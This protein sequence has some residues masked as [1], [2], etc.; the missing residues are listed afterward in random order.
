M[1]TVESPI[2]G[3]S[4][5]V[6]TSIKDSQRLKALR[7]Y[8]ILDTE[9]EPA[10][11]RVTTMAAHLFDA[12]VSI[13]N[14]VEEDRQW[15]KSTV[16]MDEQETGLDVSF[17]IYTVANEAPFV[18]EDLAADDRFA[19]NPYVVEDGIRFYAGAPLTTP[20][21]Q[22]LGTVCVLDTQPRSPPQEQ[23][24]RLSDLAAMVVDEL[25]LRREHAER[26]KTA[27]R[28]RQSRELLQQSQRL[29]YVGGW[30]YDVRSET[31]SWTEET[32]RIHGCSPTDSI[33]Y[34]TALSFYGPEAQSTLKEHFDRLL[35]EGEAYDLEL[36]M[37]TTEGDQRWV[38]TIGEA[39]V[40]GGNVV[41]V[42]GAIQDITDRRRAR[43]QLRRQ[44][45]VLQTVFDN[46]PVMIA[47][48]DEKGRFQM[49]NQK[50]ETMLGWTQ[51]DVASRADAV[52]R[53][54]P[55]PDDQQAAID[56]VQEASGTWEEFE[57]RNKAGNTK[58]VLGTA[59]ALRDGRRIG[60][61]FDV[62]EKKEREERLRL[63]EAAV[64][65]TRVPVLITE[66][67]PLDEPGPTVVYANPAVEEV[68]GYDLNEIQGR[69][70][71]ML[72]G[73]D[74]DRAKLGRIRSALENE[75]PVQEVVRNYTKDGTMYWNDIYIAPVRDETG[76]VT[77]FASVQADVTERIQR[78]RELKEAKEAAEEADRIKGALL[79]NMSHEFR[80]PLTSI[81][82]FAQLLTDKP[83]LA[84]KF[85]DRI[86]GGGQRLLR[87]LNAVM[88][89]AELEGG[90]ITPTPH[91]VAVEDVAVS[92]VNTFQEQARRRDVTLQVDSPDETVS[93]ELDKHFLERILTHL[94]SN[95]VK[96]NEE[97][98]TVKIG[99]RVRDETFELCV[100]D[101]GIGIPPEAQDE[102]FDEF[103]QVST[104]D[105]RTHDGNGIGLT[106]V[107][108]M[109]RRMGGTVDLQSTPGEGTRVT[110]RLPRDASDASQ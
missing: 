51:G 23:L 53:F 62:S 39:H 73:E 105:D 101:T 22:R 3:G 107:Q 61:G 48:F 110:V 12:P 76:A 4:P 98:G 46:I 52:E 34:D 57:V 77:H 45:D 50:F 60:I 25:E 103:Y 82:S 41:R 68:T 70:P 18:V 58:H 13:I 29:A 80:T 95:A 11:D 108:R 28:L 102:V 79:A 6:R 16:G 7:R 71:R 59:V 89:F 97:G 27:E 17:C 83:A 5:S 19:D 1:S 38:R 49:V 32:Y 44:K 96:F 94:V 75:E 91:S 42:N 84:E 85:A 86:L 55:D 56:F 88:D 99:I 14:F 72:Q 93:V 64:E 9:P 33:D 100:E 8:G 67:A 92:V 65:Y 109:V 20:D 87:T 30:E 106:I 78:R 66:A 31:L 63:L 104:G 81:I 15:F 43:Q 26:T 40:E 36:P 37:T 2:S 24:E 47:L 21:G 54:F 90:E 69:S 35:E 10:F 74:T